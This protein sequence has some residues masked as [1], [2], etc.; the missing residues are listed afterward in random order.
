MV[1]S[2]SG[3]HLRSA[4]SS[5]PERLISRCVIPVPF[6]SADPG[7]QS[8]TA[9]LTSQSALV[10]APSAAVVRPEGH[11]SHAAANPVANLPAG[12]VAQLRSVVL[13]GGE[14][15]H[16]PGRHTDHAT[17]A[18]LPGSGWYL[19]TG[20]PLHA[21]AL[22]ALPKVPAAHS[23]H[24]MEPGDS[25]NLLAGH[26]WHAVTVLSPSLLYVFFVLL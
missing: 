21:V 5:L 8:E 13:L 11:A 4:V 23:V 22:L 26:M 16:S 6:A 9:V 14:N 12:Q 2:A 20:H 18:V 15:S 25:A 17:H 10:W 19:P 1:S 24:A 3:S 7:S